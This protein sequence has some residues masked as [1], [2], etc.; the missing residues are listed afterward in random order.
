MKELNEDTV[1]ICIVFLLQLMM[2]VMSKRTNSD[3]KQKAIL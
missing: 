2:S 1:L 3:H